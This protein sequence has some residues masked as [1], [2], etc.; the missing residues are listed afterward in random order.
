MLPSVRRRAALPLLS[1]LVALAAAP[2]AAQRPAADSAALVTV[3][4]SDTLALERWVRTPGHVAAEVA[5]RSPRTTLRR[6]TLDLTPE[7]RMRRYEERV[8]DPADPSR[9]PLRTETVEPAEGGGWTRRLTEGDSTRTARIEAGPEALPWVDLVHWPFELALPAVP[10]GDTV[11]RPFLAGGRALQYRLARTAPDRVTLTHPLRGPSTVRT[12]AAGRLLELDAAETTRKVVVTR[13]PWLDV[14]APARRWAAADR[15]GRGMG[16]LSGRAEEE[17]TV[18]G[19]RIALDYGVPVRRGR[20][21]FGN[22]VQWGEVWRTG[23]NRATHLS[24]DREIVLGDPSGPTLVVPAGDYTLFSIPE[25]A[26]GT[27]I[28]NR[29]TGQKGTA[30][31]P[32]QDLGRVPMRR[33]ELAEPVERFTIRAEPDGA[34]GA[35]RLAWDRSEF[36]V[37][38]AV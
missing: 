13:V 34:R 19:A 36:V 16:E 14:A 9:P 2:A 29:Q 10:A 4:G 30:Y 22:V 26:G 15:A 35:L 25:E 6:Y 31:D 21:I 12:D 23:A 38:F 17:F 33:R 11:S 18:G 8:L 27:L 3:L 5:V 28:V 7:G 1:A 32:A 24:T 20:D 37:P